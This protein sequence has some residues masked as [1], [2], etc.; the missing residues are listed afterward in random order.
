MRSQWADPKVLL[1]K[2]QIAL[3]KISGPVSVANSDWHFV[4]ECRTSKNR[5]NERG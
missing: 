5:I 3:E 1:E 2:R 4:A